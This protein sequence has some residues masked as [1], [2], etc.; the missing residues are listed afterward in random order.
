M[1]VQYWRALHKALKTIL[2]TRDLPK[3]PLRPFNVLKFSKNEYASN[4]YLAEYTDASGGLLAA[5]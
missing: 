1:Y 2:K 5:R 4:V 3:P